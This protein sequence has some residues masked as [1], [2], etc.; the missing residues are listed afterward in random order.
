MQIAE[1]FGKRHDSVLRDIKEL[2]CSAEFSF[3]NFVESRIH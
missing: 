1:T 2:E 3:H